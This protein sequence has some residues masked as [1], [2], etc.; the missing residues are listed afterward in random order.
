MNT[1][2][3]DAS[4]GL[5][6]P[7]FWDIPFSSLLP[8]FW[9]VWVYMV[10]S[11]YA[12][13]RCRWW[14]VYTKHLTYLLRLLVKTMWCCMKVEHVCWCIRTCNMSVVIKFCCRQCLHSAF[15]ICASDLYAADVRS[16]GNS[17]LG[18]KASIPAMINCECANWSKSYLTHGV[19]VLQCLSLVYY[20]VKLA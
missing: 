11:V 15:G 8:V 13:R 5:F 18:L 4:S 2:V 16:N 6:A 3:T 9:E 17:Y 20:S 14:S 10:C 19:A 12:S 7:C 1:R